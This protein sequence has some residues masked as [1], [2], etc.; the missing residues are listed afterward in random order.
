MKKVLLLLLA[1]MLVGCSG[2]GTEKKKEADVKKEDVVEKEPAEE[3]KVVPVK[4]EEVD[5]ESKAAV[6]K[7]V[8]K[9]NVRVDIY[10]QDPVDGMEIAKIPEPITSDLNKEENIFSQVLLDTDFIKHK[11]HYKIDA[12]YNEDK[13]II[14]YYI[15]IEGIPAT[16]LSEEGEEWAEGILSSM[17]IAWGLG[18]D[19]DKFDEESDIALD[20]EKPTYTYTDPNT[21]TNVTFLFADW[22][23]GKFE[24]K[25]DL[26]K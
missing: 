20:E 10:K 25:Y 18:L 24:I 11:G 5:P 14:G 13:K 4:F 1:V 16:E 21:K 8:K 19:I 2:E 6:E 17:A 7:L 22:D 15:S 12:R 3:K 9:Y 26:S 23:L